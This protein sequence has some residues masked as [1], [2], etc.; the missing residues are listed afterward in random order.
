M[1][2]FL[3]ILLCICCAL[4]SYSQNEKPNVIFIMC[5]DLNDYQGVFGGHP[6]AHTPNIDAMAAKGVQ[7]LNAQSNAPVCQPSRNSLFTGVYPHDSNDFGWTKRTRQAVL[8]NNK[9]LIQLFKENGY[10]TLGSGKLLH[11]NH[12]PQSWDEWGMNTK[13]NY[14]PFAF[15]GENRVAHPK[16]PQPYQS[17]GP[18][19]GSYGRLSTCDMWVYGWDGKPFRYT[20]DE[21]R[22]LM[23]DELHAQWATKKIKELEASEN[24]QPFFMGVGFVNPHTP[25]H[26]PDRF[27]EMFPI[28]DLELA[29]WLASDAED[30]YLKDNINPNNKGFRYYRMLMESY[31]G[32]RELALKH[33]LQAYLACVAF[34][35]E[36]IGKVL[37]A[38]ENSRFKNNTIVIFTADHGWQMGEK[39]YLF[40]NSPW[41]ESARVPMVIMAPE[42]KAGA[43]VEQPVSL[44][45]IYPTLVEYCNLSG[46]NKLNNQAGE[47]GGFS[48]L[49]LFDDNDNTIW[50]GPNGALTIV[51]NIG[52]KTT[53]REQHY[54][55][56]TRNWRYI[57]YANGKEELYNHKNDVHEWINLEDDPNYKMVKWSLYKE[58][59]DIIGVKL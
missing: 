32:D 50:R 21:D 41:D 38:L 25:L 5:D 52:T 20:N 3:L 56:R 59:C 10:Y 19:D 34:V 57:R 13:H 7:F 18:V 29:P 45:D 17:I 37:N 40:K 51:G 2:Y 35:D 28:D 26:A 11:G 30:T 23:Q 27:F 44:V 9:T 31:D 55:Y 4:K 1:K 8:K 6:Q 49:P 58:V 33:F 22:D 36:Q 48:M 16:V 15:D 53:I 43:K 47:L 42:A 46:S 54:S 12:E 39:N 24:N 14:G